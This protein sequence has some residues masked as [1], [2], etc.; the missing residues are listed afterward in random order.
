M[1]YNANP[2]HMSLEELKC[3]AYCLDRANHQDTKQCNDGTYRKQGKVAVG[4]ADDIS[5]HH[6]SQRLRQSIGNIDDTH[7]FAPVIHGGQNLGHQGRVYSDV[8]AK[9]QTQH[10]HVDEQHWPGW[11]Q[12]EYKH[13]RRNDH[14]RKHNKQFT[15]FE[16]IG[17]YAPEQ[18]R[19]KRYQ[20]RDNRQGRDALFD[21]LTWKEFLV[22]DRILQV[23]KEIAST[24][25]IAE[26]RNEARQPG[27]GKIRMFA[28]RSN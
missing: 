15:P 21:P 23:I 14:I 11:N 25:E 2:E 12:T 19:D 17:E 28:D 10:R 1:L 6:R 5:R 22:M 16:A 13:R 26:A 18:Y 24:Q 3:L 9:A 20:S 4:G 8:C 27:P 7:I